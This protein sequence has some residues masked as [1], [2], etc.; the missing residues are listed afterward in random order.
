MSQLFV[1]VTDPHQKLWKLSNFSKHMEQ[2]NK[3]VTVRKS[4]FGYNC[5][6]NH[7]R[8]RRKISPLHCG[9]FCLSRT[10]SKKKFQHVCFL[11]LETFWAWIVDLTIW[12]CVGSRIR[13]LE[14]PEGSAIKTGPGWICNRLDN[15]TLDNQ[16][17]LFWNWNKPCGRACSWSKLRI[18]KQLAVWFQIAGM[19][20]PHETSLASVL[21]PELLRFL[22]FHPPDSILMTYNSIVISSCHTSTRGG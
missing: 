18:W 16:T 8:D 7:F 21:R 11:G 5:S 4:V 12:L 10:W 2:L 20:S 22:V 13:L 6:A 9:Q 14:K 15:Q 19:I 1:A 3:E 17:R